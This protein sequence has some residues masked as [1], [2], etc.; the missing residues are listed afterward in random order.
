MSMTEERKGELE[1]EAFQNDM[2]SI[3]SGGGA[4]QVGRRRKLKA[5][6]LIESP[7][8]RFGSKGKSR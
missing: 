6:N 7:S 4:I 1:Y 2:A 8:R 3:Y 5:E